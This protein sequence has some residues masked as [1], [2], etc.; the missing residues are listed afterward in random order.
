M[1]GKGYTSTYTDPDGKEHRL[2]G[3]QYVPMKLPADESFKPV[4]IKREEECDHQLYVCLKCVQSW[5]W[6]YIIHF[7]RTQGGRNL[8]ATVDA[9]GI[10]LG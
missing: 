10:K 9:A 8:K 1:A 7:H 4:L 6:D 3:A 5:S 2:A